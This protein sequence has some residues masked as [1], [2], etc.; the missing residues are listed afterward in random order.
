[1][2]ERVERLS[3]FVDANVLVSGARVETGAS[4]VLLRLG[5]VGLLDLVVSEQVLAEAE[6]AFFRLLPSALPAFRL[7]V[8]AACRR[9]D[10]LPP[11]IV[12]RYR[13]RAHPKDAPILAAAVEARC[14]SLVTFNTRDFRP[15]ASE[16]LIETP[17]ELIARLRARLA[18]LGDEPP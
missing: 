12:A 4:R 8:E 9:V 5:E 6:R 1:M 2:V 13:A 3:V 16:I 10:D 18:S 14:S 7:L 17:A 11:K 15:R